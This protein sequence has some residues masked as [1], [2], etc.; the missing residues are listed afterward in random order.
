MWGLDRDP[1][2]DYAVIKGPNGSAVQVFDSSDNW[3]LPADDQ[4]KVT[5]EKKVHDRCTTEDP[6]AKLPAD[7]V[8]SSWEN[9][10]STG[11]YWVGGAESKRLFTVKDYEFLDRYYVPDKKAI[12]G[13]R[14]NSSTYKYRVQSTTQGGFAITKD[15]YV[16]VT[17]S[18]DECRVYNVEPAD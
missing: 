3:Q 11:Q 4:E 8:L 5:A 1:G 10:S 16:D 15:W 14:P 6:M 13:R 18:G 7:M 17:L 12:D 9:G 2:K